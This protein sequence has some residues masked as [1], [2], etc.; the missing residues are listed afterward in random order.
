MAEEIGQEEPDEPGDPEEWFDQW[1][2]S[3]PEWLRLKEA[4]NGATTKRRAI[5]R[6]LKRKELEAEEAPKLHQAL[7]HSNKKKN[8]T[9]EEDEDQEE[10]EEQTEQEPRFMVLIMKR[11]DSS[12]EGDGT[13]KRENR[14]RSEKAEGR[15][16]GSRREST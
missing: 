1:E 16:A 9:E 13:R 2:I 7:K 8:Q 4:S 10:Q 6:S 5:K 12:T 15:R 14:L 11:D 3:R